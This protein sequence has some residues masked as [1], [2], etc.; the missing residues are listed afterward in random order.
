MVTKDKK[1]PNLYLKKYMENSEEN[2]HV[3]FGAATFNF[4]N[5]NRPH[6]HEKEKPRRILVAVAKWHLY[7][8]LAYSGLSC[9]K[10]D[11][12]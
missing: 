2:L 7:E 3:D 10:R 5:N 9:S 1:S 12:S 8:K 6:L 11:F 4:L